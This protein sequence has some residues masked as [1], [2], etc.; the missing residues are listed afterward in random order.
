MTCRYRVFKVS[1]E[2]EN[3]LK[4]LAL[5][6]ASNVVKSTAGFKKE[7]EV[8]VYGIA[9]KCAWAGTKVIPHSVILKAMTRKK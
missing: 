4:K 7:K 6:K 9:M 3:V 5:V 8:S 1:G 2:L